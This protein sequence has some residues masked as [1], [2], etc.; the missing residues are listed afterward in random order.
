MYLLHLWF[1]SPP[2]NG[3]ISVIFINPSQQLNV[4]FLQDTEKQKGKQAMPEK[5]ENEMS[6]VKQKSRKL[7]NVKKEIPTDA[8]PR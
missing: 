8:K 4:N 1:V 2:S 6:Q 5:P 7:L 3:T